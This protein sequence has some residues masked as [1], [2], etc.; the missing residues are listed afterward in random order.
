MAATSHYQLFVL[1]LLLNLL[2]L[3]FPS[4][5][6]NCLKKIVYHADAKTR[7]ILFEG[8]EGSDVNCRLCFYPRTGFAKN[9][10]LEVTWLMFKVSDDMPDCEKSYIE[11]SLTRYVFFRCICTLNFFKVPEGVRGCGVEKVGHYS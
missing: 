3:G 10:F 1:Q 11:L 8:K 6:S 9:H 7:S 4:V 2:I 5:T